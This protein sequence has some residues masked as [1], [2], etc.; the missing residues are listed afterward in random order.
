MKTEICF[1][2]HGSD[3]AAGTS[4]KS[5]TAQPVEQRSLLSSSDRHINA[6]DRTEGPALHHPTSGSRGLVLRFQACQLENTSSVVNRL[7]MPGA[8][9]PHYDGFYIRDTTSN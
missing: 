3:Q 2:T 6:K 5:E 8:E 9:V 7:V 4:E 1:T